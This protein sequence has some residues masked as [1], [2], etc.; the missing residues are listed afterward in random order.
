MVKEA[1]LPFD[2]MALREDPLE[3][4]DCSAKASR[5]IP[6]GNKMNVIRHYGQAE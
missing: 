1:L 4:H 6:S 3:R 5:M 2:G